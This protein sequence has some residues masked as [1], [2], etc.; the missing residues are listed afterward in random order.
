MRP[1][2]RS[3]AGNV[4]ALLRNIRAAKRRGRRMLGVAPS[5]PMRILALETAPA[6]PAAPCT[7]ELLRAE[8]AAVWQL[9]QKDVVRALWFTRRGKRAVLLLECA[10]EE[11]AHRHLA[12]LPLVR[13][14]CIAFEVHALRAYDGFARLFAPEKTS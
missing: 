9:Q 11:E 13:A 6:A 14:S 8:A 2:G 3:A 1:A 5:A 12:S 4:R 10:S 7:P